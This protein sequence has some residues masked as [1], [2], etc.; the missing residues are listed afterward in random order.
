WDSAPVLVAGGNL[1]LSQG[2]IWGDAAHGGT[3]SAKNVSYV[4]GAPSQG[5]PVDFATRAAQVRTLST[6][7]ASL[8]ANSLTRRESWGGLMLS[9][10]STHVN[11]FDVNASDFSGTVLLSIDAPS[12]SLVVLNI[13]GSSATLSGGHSFSGGI[14][15]RGI[16]FNFVDAT[17]IN[18]SRYSLWGTLLAPN[19]HVN[20]NNGSFDGGLYAKSLSGNAEGHLNPLGDWDLCLPPSLSASQ[21]LALSSH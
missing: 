5:F 1:T 4:R 21:P 2:G 8:P 14:D 20:F 19:A 13:R 11:V 7:L 10:S 15:Q 3:Y 18:A 12:G 17:S 16:L 9:G 6:R